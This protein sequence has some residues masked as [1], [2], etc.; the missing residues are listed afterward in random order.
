MPDPRPDLTSDRLRPAFKP[1]GRIVFTLVAVLAFTGLAPLGTVGWKLIDINREALV[2]AH[3]EYQLLMAASLAREIEIHVEGLRSQLLRVSQTVGRSVRGAEDEANEPVQRV[4]E[5]VVGERM[6]YLRFT[7]FRA[8]APRTIETGELPEGLSRLFRAGLE[9]S[10]LTLAREAASRPESTILSEPTVLATKPVTAGI[11]IS[12]PVVSGGRFVGVLSALVDLSAVWDTIV[13]RHRTGHALFVLDR[14]GRVLASTDAAH[15]EPGSDVSRTPLVSRFLAAE[16]RARE[17]LPFRGT[18]DGEEREYIGSYEVTP[19]GWGVFVQAHLEDVYSPV[20]G[21][22]D[23]VLTWA[24]L[25]LGFAVAAAVVFADTLARPIKQLAAV[26]RSF[27][28]GDFSS[29]AGVRSGSEI[30]ELAHTFNRMADEIEDH[31]R[32]LR[33]AAEENRELFLGTIQ[34][35]AEAIDAKDPYTRGHS[36]RVNRYSV[37]IGRQLRLTD[38]Q[39]EELHVASL[40]HD[41]GKIGIHDRILQKPGTLTPDEFEIM[42]THATLGAQILAPIKKMHRVIPGLRWHHER[43]GGGGYPDGLEGDT[44]PLMARIIAVADTFD[45]MTTHRP[46]QSAMSVDEA[47]ERLISLRGVA[48]DERVVEAFHSAYREGQIVLDEDPAAAAAGVSA[49]PATS[50]RPELVGG[51]VA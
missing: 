26:S 49:T 46:Y 50:K 23:S 5:D 33:R 47:R 14:S 28:D 6:L 4:L 30:G 7:Q 36:A 25:A 29:R 45:A 38:D 41:V 40:M 31:I 1:R 9:D 12:A 13:E 17:T 35:M 19:Q 24:L 10:V 32:R 3:Q 8:T 43:W 48:F 21:M 34:A 51:G 18:E 2:T 20:R 15:L 22:V 39:L 11:V 42:K 27:A 16:G 44:I 37:A